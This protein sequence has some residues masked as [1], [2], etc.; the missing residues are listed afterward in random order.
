MRAREGT[1]K[2]EELAAWP[3]YWNQYFHGIRMHLKKH[4]RLA[5][6]DNSI[7]LISRSVEQDALLL[8]PLSIPIATNQHTIGYAAQGGQAEVEKEVPKITGHR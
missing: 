1:K 8:S 5:E 7:V 6:K 2:G 3:Q 4:D